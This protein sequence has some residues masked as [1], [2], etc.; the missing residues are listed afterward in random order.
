LILCVSLK[1]A[2]LHW[3]HI[4]AMSSR[5]TACLVEVSP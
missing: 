4:Q 3:D 5:I 2:M 1:V